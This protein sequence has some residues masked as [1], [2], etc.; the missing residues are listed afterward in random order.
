MNHAFCD[1]LSNIE[2]SKSIVSQHMDAATLNCVQ[3]EI[4]QRIADKTLQVM[5]Y[6][7]YNAG[8]STLVNALLGA[9]SAVVNDIPTTDS[10]DCYDWNGYHLLDTPGVNAP[11]EHE[12]TTNEQI[13]RTSAM[14][15][16]IREGDQD[17]KDVYERLF[18][19]VKQ[20]KHIFVVL[21]HQLTNIQD[22]IAAHRQI[23]TILCQ[24]ASQYGVSEEQVRD[25]QIY[26]MNV[27]TA[28]TGRLKQSEKLLEHSGYLDFIAAF[29]D[30]VQEQETQVRLLEEVK[31]LIHNL[32]YTPALDALS[33][34]ESDSGTLRTLNDECRQ[35]TA[36][37]N[38]LKIEARSHISHEVTLLKSEVSQIL[39]SSTDQAQFESRL[40]SL[41]SP[42]YGQIEAWLQNQLGRSSSHL[43]VDLSSESVIEGHGLGS[44]S[45][46]IVDNA[47]SQMRQFVSN[48]GNLKEA[49]L[50]GR[51]L[52]IP[53]LKGRWEKTLGQWAGKAAIAIQVVTFFWDAYS[54]HSE[55]EKQNQA[56]RQQAI[57][58]YQA[59]EEICNKVNR[60]LTQAVN[61]MIDAFFNAQ[62]GL[63]EEQ[64]LLIT[65]S[66]EQQKQEHH[67]LQKFANDLD[68]IAL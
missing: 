38:A 45:N 17:A 27:K 47:L 57:E 61:D 63:L 30:W 44:V 65:E 21:N 13:K 22:K 36:H 58:I 67:L 14:L 8:K 42:L 6:G 49:L 34:F 51:K 37:Q 24:L 10:I 33:Y 4:K 54:A 55:Q 18:D 46:P 59:V 25:I 62:R 48:E 31:G 26:P 28:L 40:Q 7:S 66:D 23:M 50:M 68:A 39:R 20:G 12:N 43:L 29:S 5:L 52:K 32:W 19:M 41:F 11:I 15:F 3:S 16:V 35:Q 60:E 64:V 53:G 9:E 56:Q 1:I 2:Q